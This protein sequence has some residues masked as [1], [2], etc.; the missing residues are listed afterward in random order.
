MGILYH[1]CIDLEML[2]LFLPRIRYGLGGNAKTAAFPVKKQSWP[3]CPDG[4]IMKGR[5]NEGKGK[6]RRWLQT[7]EK[8]DKE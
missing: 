7:E 2:T 1:F 5:K 6:G 8:E 3:V 4:E